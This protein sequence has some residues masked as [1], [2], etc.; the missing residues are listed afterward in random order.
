LEVKQ[1][2]LP[3]V[4]VRIFSKATQILFSATHSISRKFLKC[5]PD[6]LYNFISLFP[7]ADPNNIIN[8]L[9]DVNNKKIDIQ[10]LKKLAD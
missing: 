8:N 7:V 9:I 1:V 6:L 5:V 4:G 2:G 10:F 3:L